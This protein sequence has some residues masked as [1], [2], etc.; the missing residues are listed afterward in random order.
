M[1]ARQALGGEISYRPNQPLQLNAFDLA[2]TSYNLGAFLPTQLESSGLPNDYIQGYQRKPVTQAQ[3]SLAQTFDQV[4]KASRLTVVGEVG[5]NHI[6]DI[7][8]GSGDKPRFGRDAVFGSGEYTQQSLLGTNICETLLNPQVE[9]CNDKGFYTRN[10]WGYRI[11]ANLEYSNVIAGINLSPTIA[12]SHD[13]EG[14]GP[15]FNEGAKAISI[16]LN[17]D[18]LNTYTASIAYTDFFGGTY[19]SLV[20]RD[21]A[22]VTFGAHF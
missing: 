3:M 1:P 17:A 7:G 5:Y 10:S 2:T 13:V 16:G 15:N 8:E 18:Y 12:W 14:Y 4:W 21:F 19:N 22:S 6:A 20:D 11:R 9:N